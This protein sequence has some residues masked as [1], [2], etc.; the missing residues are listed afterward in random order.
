MNEPSHLLDI[1]DRLSRI[2]SVTNE[3]LAQAKRTNGRVTVLEGKVDSLEST[4]DA[5]QGSARAIGGVWKGMAS[6]GGVAGGLALLS[7]LFEK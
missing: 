4:R 5:Q 1:V 7:K 6:V 2:E 3:T